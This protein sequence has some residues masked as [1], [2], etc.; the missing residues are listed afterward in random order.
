MPNNNGNFDQTLYRFEES[1]VPRQ[2]DVF[3]IELKSFTFGH[4]IL[5]E[6]IGNK[7]VSKKILD[8]PV[9]NCLYDFFTAVILCGVS[10]E[11]GLYLINNPTSFKRLIDDFSYN[12][13]VSMSKKKLWKLYIK[14]SWWMINK[15]KWFNKNIHQKLFINKCNFNFYKDIN[16]FKLYMAYYMEMPLYTVNKTGK[17][18][19]QS[20]TD[21]KNN[22]F[23]LFKKQGYSELEILN[24]N[25]KKIWVEW[26]SYAENE[27]A[28]TVINKHEFNQLEQIRLNKK[29]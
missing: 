7:V 13:V 11:Q 17:Q 19:S 29:K 14:S 18:T 4:L 20:G 16:K 6:R 23:T 1:L 5:L 22:I 26:T 25:M 27:G 12:L 2:W 8:E 24:M 28:I 21:W 9:N 10:Y 15:S 3:G